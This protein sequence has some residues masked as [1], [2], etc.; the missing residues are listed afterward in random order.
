MGAQILERCLANAPSA[1]SY[2]R[3]QKVVLAGFYAGFELV[4]EGP[5]KLEGIG[6]GYFLSFRFLDEEKSA[7]RGK[8]FYFTCGPLIS[9][10][11]LTG[12][13]EPDPQRDHLFDAIGKTFSFRQID[14]LLGAKAGGLT[15]EI[16]RT[17]QVDTARVW[18]GPWREFPFAGV[19]VPV[20]SGW[21]IGEAAGVIQFQRGK[22]EIRLHRE[23][24]ENRELN[25]WFARRLSDMQHSGDRLLGVEHGAA[26]MGVYV[27]IL[28]EEKGTVRTWKTAATARSLSLFMEGR[29]PLVW[30]LRAPESVFSEPQRLFESMVAATRFLGPAEW[31][32]R[33]PFPWAGFVLKGPWEVHGPGF[34]AR[35]GER[36]LLVQASE[37]PS[38]LPLVKIRP[39]VLNS[40]R[41][42]F[43]PVRGQERENLGLLKRREAFRYFFD[44]VDEKGRPVSIRLL[45]VNSRNT[46]F[47]LAVRGA[48][49]AEVEPLFLGL[50]E[51]MQLL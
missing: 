46:L 28:Y 2:A 36:P 37:V 39:S 19:S 38:D 13:A 32:T 12:Q 26:A 1:E 15:S 9:Q 6:E 45:C 11:L 20:P 5:Q 8:T 41:R 7:C 49:A 48:E 44:G 10:L 33:L 30:T 14:F 21:E 24:G 40:L 42:D 4:E 18:P 25:P 23:I 31:E 22:A 16:L 43:D 35:L 51:A 3:E 34:Y 47:Q 17:P 27:A 29:Q 50:V